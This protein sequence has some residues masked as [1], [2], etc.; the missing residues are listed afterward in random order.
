MLLY[1]RFSCR[2]VFRAIVPS[3]A[4]RSYASA[5]FPDDTNDENVPYRT[6]IAHVT[7]M[8]SLNRFNLAKIR[9]EKFLS[10]L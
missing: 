7:A 4:R 10:Q 8:Q 3:V 5:I 1:S 6:N 2:M 9:F